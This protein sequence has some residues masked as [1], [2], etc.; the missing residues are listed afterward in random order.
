M[1][2]HRFL[3]M[4]AIN[5]E[6]LWRALTNHSRPVSLPVTRNFPDRFIELIATNRLT[7]EF[8]I[9]C[10]SRSLPSCFG[11]STGNAMLKVRSIRFCPSCLRECFHSPLFQLANVNRCPLHECELLVA[12]EQ[13]GNAIGRP[14]FNPREFRHP[15]ACP[16]CNRSFAVALNAESALSGFAAGKEMFSGL[17]HWMRRFR[18][19]QFQQISAL[20][21]EPWSPLDYRTICAELAVFTGTPPNTPRW[22]DREAPLAI[23][24]RR[25][26]TQFSRS[27]KFASERFL[28]PLK[29]DFVA[30]CA[31]AKSLN[32]HISKRV[33]AICRHRRTTHLPWENAPH[34][35]AP[36]QPVLLMSPH[37]CPCC[38]ILDQWRA[39]AG[40]LLALRDRAQSWNAPAI[41]EWHLGD[42]RIAFSLEPGTCASALLSTFTWF[43][44][45]LNRVVQVLA[46]RE[47]KFWY[48]NEMEFCNRRRLNCN[49]LPLD[50]H[51]FA[52]KPHGYEFSTLNEN[53][54]L[55]YSLEHALK[56]LEA[57]YTLYKNGVYWL[58]KE[59]D[60]NERSMH[61]REN[62]WYIP[63]SLYFQTRQAY[64][65]WINVPSPLPLSY[66]VGTQN[67]AQ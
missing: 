60:A 10:Q 45:A 29:P 63:M 11:P 37:D 27:E 48:D 23:I 16:N 46:E 17:E 8:A 35:F 21:G 4:N 47:T 51:R 54:L 30:A 15:L 42:F 39:Y 20:G 64:S 9:H 26:K 3:W 53:I 61:D 31:I 67:S 6:D 22:L 5:S 2:W 55:M 32:R 19:I 49:V 34:S 14:A 38:A 33:R 57:S 28:L 62:D 40:K 24:D 36:V 44:S 18:S 56:S 25:D 65:Q 66:F 13:C 1:A 43:A 52:I 59:S 41:Y 50:V 58:R 7:K 12:C